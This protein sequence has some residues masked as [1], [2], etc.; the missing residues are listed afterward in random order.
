M[1]FAAKTASELT[2]VSMPGIHVY[3]IEER[4]AKLHTPQQGW[5]TSIHRKATCFDKDSPEGRAYVCI[6]RKLGGGGAANN[7]EQ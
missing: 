4:S 7:Y 2:Y 1:N 3:A 6:H 5:P